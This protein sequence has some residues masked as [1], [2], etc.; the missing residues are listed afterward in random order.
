MSTRMSKRK[1]QRISTLL[2]HH[3]R[4]AQ[5]ALFFLMKENQMR[6]GQNTNCVSS[7]LRKRR[8]NR[9]TGETLVLVFLEKDVDDDATY[10]LLVAQRWR[11]SVDCSGAV[12]YGGAFCFRVTWS[13]RG[14]MVH[15]SYSLLFSSRNLFRDRKGRKWRSEMYSSSSS[16]QYWNSLESSSSSSRRCARVFWS[17]ASEEEEKEEEE[18]EKE[19]KRKGLLVAGGH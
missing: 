6:G 5:G 8:D 12:F 19:K 9:I 16:W 7:L 3:W 11:Q 14:S 18:E 2:R 17:F 1:K 15:N 13:R 10:L 4:T